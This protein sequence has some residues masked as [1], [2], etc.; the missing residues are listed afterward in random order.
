MSDAHYPPLALYIGGQWLWRTSGGEIPVINPADETELGTLPLAGVGELDAA[1]E[2]AEMG[3]RIWRR[4]SACERQKIISR[5]TKLL[6]E[7]AAHIAVALTLEQGK[8]Y[9]QAVREVVLGAEIIDFLAEEGKRLYGRTV[10]PRTPNVLSQLV[11]RHPVGPVAAFTPWNFPANLPSRKLGGAL[12]AGCSVIIKPAEETPAT[13]MEFVR[14]FHDAG[15]PPGVL[16]MVCG[17]PEEVSARLIASPVVRKVSF[18]GSVRV[19]RLLGELAAK[20]IKRYTAELGGHAPVIVCQDADAVQ[21]AKVSAVA[22]FRNGG[23]VCTSPTRFYV[24]HSNFKLFCSAFAAEAKAIRVG[25]GLEEGVVMGPLANRRRLDD[26][27][28]FVDD[29]VERG[30]KLL[31]GGH[32]VGNTGYFFA[33]TV[34]AELP[35]AAR[36][37]HEEPF[38]PIAILQSFDT[39]DEAIGAAN[40][41]P[42]GLAAYGFTHDIAIAHRLG[43]E[44]EAGMVGINHFGV[45]QPETPFGGWK[46]SGFGQESGLEGLLGYTDVKLFSIAA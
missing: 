29:A 17:R 12:A 33:P 25:P 26:M 6:R 39:L 8:P 23:Q 22:K 18:T 20:G 5:T 37:L 38:G 40:G 1:L 14:A 4:T 7:R 27:Q 9:A 31:C 36:V 16:N 19:G 32:R 13:C 24:H 30:G 2:A 41:L 3:F 44:L 28:R 45:S 46:D 11:A 10:P 42:Y 21:A 35:A 15:L 34:L 43:D